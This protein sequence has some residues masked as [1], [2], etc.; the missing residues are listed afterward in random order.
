MLI[1]SNDSGNSRGGDDEDGYDDDDDTMTMAITMTHLKS[2][3]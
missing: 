3:T 1:M 2:C